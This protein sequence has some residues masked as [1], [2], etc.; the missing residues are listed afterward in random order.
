MLLLMVRG[1]D[2]GESGRGKTEHA[3]G[4]GDERVLSIASRGGRKPVDEIAELH[5]FVAEGSVSAVVRT[6]YL[7]RRRL[8]KSHATEI[9][10]ILVERAIFWKK[11][12][13]IQSFN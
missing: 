4:G 5:F 8:A 9:V 7:Q 6:T 13:R 10:S 1:S 12:Q 2:S 3:V 11:E